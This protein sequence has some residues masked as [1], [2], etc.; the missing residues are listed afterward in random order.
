[1]ARID[2]YIRHINYANIYYFFFTDECIFYLDNLSGNRWVKFDE[3]NIIYSKNKMKKDSCI[4]KISY[5]GKTSLF[6]YI[7]NTSSV[8]YIEILKKALEEIRFKNNS[9][10]L[11]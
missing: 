2:W 9:N 10:K 4:G 5:Q 11:I 7:D 3:D 1:M 6:L 8:N